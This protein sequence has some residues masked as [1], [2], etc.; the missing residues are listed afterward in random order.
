[1]AVR[2]EDAGGKRMR[3]GACRRRLRGGVAGGVLAF[4][5]KVHDLDGMCLAWVEERNGA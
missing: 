1:M 2:N 4:A 3:M 5:T